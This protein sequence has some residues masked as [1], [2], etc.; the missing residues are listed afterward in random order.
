MPA[1][2]DLR[3]KGLTNLMTETIK[4]VPLEST[5][6]SPLRQAGYSPIV[7][8]VTDPC[9]YPD[10]IVW[11]PQAA[12]QADVATG[13]NTKDGAEVHEYVL[14]SDAWVVFEEFRKAHVGDVAQLQ[15]PAR[16]TGT[17]Q[18]SPVR[19]QRSGC[20]PRNTASGVKQP[21]TRWVPKG[22]GESLFRHIPCNDY[23]IDEANVMWT[24]VY[25]DEDGCMFVAF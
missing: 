18:S 24:L 19:M 22:E 8:C 7:V 14:S 16:R 13:R 21:K 2:E 9:D 5:S 25:E 3:A 1:Y 4:G 23:E 12:V 11:I 15:Q 10:V 17:S 20:G 6:D